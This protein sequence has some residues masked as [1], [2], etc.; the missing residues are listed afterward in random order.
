MAE[1]SC[2]C[3]AVR[4]QT[5]KPEQLAECNCSLCRRTGGRWA[6]FT[7]DEVSFRAGEG[8]TVGY[9]QGDRT[10]ATHHCPG[11]GCTTH[12]V[13]LGDFSDR[14]AVNARLMSASDLEG[15]RVRRFDGADTWTFLD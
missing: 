14:V 13:G 4:I 15:V 3:G 7:P 11:C 5:P 1:A 6:Y 10:L 2:H 8:T 12:W 9:V